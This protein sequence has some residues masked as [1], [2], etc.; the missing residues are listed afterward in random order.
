MVFLPGCRSISR[1]YGQLSSLLDVFGL[2]EIL[3]SAGWLDIS[4]EACRI[5]S[6]DKTSDLSSRERK[7]ARRIKGQSGGPRGCQRRE[8]ERERADKGGKGRRRPWRDVEELR[9]LRE[10]FGTVDRFNW[11]SGGG[12]VSWQAQR[13]LILLQDKSNKS[14]W[15]LS[16]PRSPT[17]L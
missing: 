6:G 17:L 3:F 1:K 14:C 10:S 2:Y 16:R 15:F 11:L 4:R 9:G 7:R 12:L 8:E 13:V 5:G